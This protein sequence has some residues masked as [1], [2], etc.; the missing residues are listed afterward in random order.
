MNEGPRTRMLVVL[1]DETDMWEDVPLYE[2][3]IRRL[4]RHEIAGA[5]ALAGIM[6]YGIHGRIH[7]RRLFGVSDDRPVAVLSVDTEDKLQAVI[8]EIKPMVREGLMFLTDVDIVPISG[9]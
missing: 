2:A 4:S 9:N 6:G 3:I 5:T 7:R 1:V 8:P